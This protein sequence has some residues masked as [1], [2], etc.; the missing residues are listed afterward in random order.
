MLNIKDMIF[1]ILIFYA[2]HLTLNIN[3]QAIC[4]QGV[5][6]LIFVL[7]ISELLCNQLECLFLEF[8]TFILWHIEHSRSNDI[9]FLPAFSFLPSVVKCCLTLRG[10]S[11]AQL[12]VQI[13]GPEK[14]L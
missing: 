8:L 11:G 12:L 10:F 5:H 2:V 6:C 7:I 3:V 13:V 14:P 9:L 1:F 4:H